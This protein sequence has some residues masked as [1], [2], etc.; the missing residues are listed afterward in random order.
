MEEPKAKTVKR[1]EKP[2]KVQASL[3]KKHMKDLM[4]NTKEDYDSDGDTEI[5]IDFNNEI[6]NTD[7]LQAV[8]VVFVLDTTGSMNAYIKGARNFIRKI[9]K[10]AENF[11][12]NF[13]NK[14][15]VVKFGLVLYRDY[16][17]SPTSYLTKVI[18]LDSRINIKKHVLCSTTCGD[19]KDE[20]EAVFQALSDCLNKISWRDNS[21]KLIFHVL[22]APP[23]GSEYGASTDNYESCPS[24]LT[25]DDIFEQMRELQID[26][27]VINFSKNIEKMINIFSQYY[28]FDVVKPDILKEA[29][30]DVSQE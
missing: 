29:D 23:H 9:M 25:P 5:V 6:K 13:N 28:N 17:F 26:Y 19:G 14:A 10:D 11:V 30:V 2:K 22:D 20:A 15:G 12:T 27:N 3:N 21:E 18:D 1:N 7:D 16:D 8:D 24:K 4:N